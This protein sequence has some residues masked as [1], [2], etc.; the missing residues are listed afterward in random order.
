MYG[1][2]PAN[3]GYQR[4]PQVQNPTAQQLPQA[5]L[6]LHLQP[7]S[8]ERDGRRYTLIVE[9]QPVRARMCGFGD[10]APALQDR[11]PI[12]PPPC[13]RLVVTDVATDTEVPVEDVDSAFFVLT[14]DLWSQD[15]HQE[16][17]IVRASSG[18][19][20]VS[21]STSTL[22][23]YP[24]SIDRPWQN[25]GPYHPGSQPDLR[26][27]YMTAGPGAG[28]YVGL[29][30][31]GPMPGQMP[32]AMHSMSPAYGYPQHAAPSTPVSANPM[33][34][35]TRNLIGSLSVNA[36]KLQDTTGKPGFWFVLQDLSVR[37]EGCFRLKMNF[38]D[39][40]NG[41][42]SGA[43]NQGKARVL[44]SCFSEFFQVYSAKK[45]PGV[46]ESTAL[47]KTFASQGIKIPIRKDGPKPNNQAEYDNDD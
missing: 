34:M 2:P 13:I 47:S 16:V 21:I 4:A 5:P 25:P 14:V 40:G 9:Q 18:A 8:L 46:I 22:T 35:F 19:P 10:K 11:R 6:P 15:G 32:Q 37:T 1:L 26:S 41:Q 28:Q 17:N 29:G 45:F 23:S 43:L 7:V 24:P 31:P 20:T 27:A 36:F 44:A 33:H 30:G 12:T 42:N 3:P 38:V 39:V